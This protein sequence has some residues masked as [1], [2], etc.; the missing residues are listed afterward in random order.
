M[1][2]DLVMPQPPWQPP[3]GRPQPPPPPR[4]T[5]RWQVGEWV[6]LAFVEDHDPSVYY[7]RHIRTGH[8]G[9]T[10]YWNAHDGWTVADG[11][12]FWHSRGGAEVCLR[13]W[14]SRL[15]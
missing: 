1:A 6:L 2:Y 7:L 11:D 13:W 10:V 12:D 4:M 5:A 8:P 9:S 3:W 15:G 14:A